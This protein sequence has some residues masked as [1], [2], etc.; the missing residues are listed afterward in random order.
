[1]QNESPENRNT[2]NSEVFENMDILQFYQMV[3]QKFTL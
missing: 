1:M 2:M 3:E